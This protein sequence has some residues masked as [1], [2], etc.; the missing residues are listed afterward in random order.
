[1]TVSVQPNDEECFLVV[2]PPNEQ[3]TVEGH[4]ELYSDDLTPDVVSVH[5]IDSASQRY[6]YRSPRRARNGKFSIS[7]SDKQNRISICM[8][9]G[10]IEE[11]KAGDVKTKPKDKR[12]QKNFG[13]APNKDNQ[14]RDIGIE[15]TI[16]KRHIQAEIHDTNDKLKDRSKLVTS[17]LSELLYYQ[18][19]R[20]V[21]EGRHHSIVEKTMH[22]LMLWSVSEILLLI[23]IAVCQVMYLRRFLERRWYM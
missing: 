8:Q 6:L 16:T 10:R 3:Y 18:E 11:T 17:R 12:R 14:P 2:F 5:V 4:F 9:N 21:R 15:W 1:M 22:Q 7:P 20:K 13:P 23:A 19:Y